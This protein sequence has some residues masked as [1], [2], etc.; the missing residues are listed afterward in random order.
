LSKSEASDGQVEQWSDKGGREAGP[1]Q[2]R[3]GRHGAG[4]RKWGAGQKVEGAAGKAEN[5]R[6]AVCNMASNTRKPLIC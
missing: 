2:R 6:A 4:R 3:G 5:R 1:L